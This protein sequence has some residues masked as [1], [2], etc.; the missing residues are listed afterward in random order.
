MFFNGSHIMKRLLKPELEELETLSNHAASLNICFTCLF[1]CMDY[2]GK[3]KSRLEY[4]E[5]EKCGY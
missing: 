3:R 5:K 4:I 1:M 2:T